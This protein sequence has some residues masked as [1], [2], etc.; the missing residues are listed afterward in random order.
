MGLNKY[1]FTST[2]EPLQ[3][4]SLVNDTTLVNEEKGAGLGRDANVTFGERLKKIQ[5]LPNIVDAFG[6][7]RE[8]GAFPTK[9]ITNTALKKTPSLSQAYQVSDNCFMAGPF[10]VA[11][12]KELGGRNSQ[13]ASLI[14]A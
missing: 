11:D 14:I 7:V 4:G 2:P 10:S 3:A 8:S 6:A 9:P 13:V 1:I 12:F 5:A